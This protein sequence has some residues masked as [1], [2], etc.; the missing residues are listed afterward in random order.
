[1]GVS[2]TSRLRRAHISPTTE[3]TPAVA[4][5]ATVDGRN[6]TARA[7]GCEDLSPACDLGSVICHTLREVKFIARSGTQTHFRRYSPL[8]CR[9]WASKQGGRMVIYMLRVK[10]NEQLFVFS[11]DVNSD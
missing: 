2:P 1:M 8:R 11:I 10:N 3:R 9:R 7:R 4:V 6:V 5:K